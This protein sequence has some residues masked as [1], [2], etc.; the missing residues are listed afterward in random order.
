MY[1]MVKKTVCV[2][3]VYRKVGVNEEY[4]R[5]DEVRSRSH[6]LCGDSERFLDLRIPVCGIAVRFIAAKIGDLGPEIIRVF[7]PDNG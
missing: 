4:G 6:H 2:I 5:K 3:R 7:V 1:F